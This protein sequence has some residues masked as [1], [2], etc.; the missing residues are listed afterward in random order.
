[1]DLGGKFCIEEEGRI[2]RAVSYERD[3]KDRGRKA[4]EGQASKGRAPVLLN[5]IISGTGKPCK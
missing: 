2:A 3:G 5:I 4:T 1:V